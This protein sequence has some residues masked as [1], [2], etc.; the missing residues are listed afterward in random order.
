MLTDRQ[1]QVIDAIASLGYQ[2][3]VARLVA[4]ILLIALAGCDRSLPE[5]IADLKAG[6]VA[7]QQ[8]SEP[9]KKAIIAD[10]LA[11]GIIGVTENM[12]ML[13]EPVMGPEDIRS[14]PSEYRDAMMDVQSAP[15]EY[16]LPAPPTP[17]PVNVLTEIGNTMTFWGGILG[18]LSIVLWLAS[19]TP[20][21]AF[22]SAGVSFIRLGISIGT[23][24]AMVG[25]AMVWIAPY[26]W[27]AV[28]LTAAGMGY[29]HRKGIMKYL[30]H[31]RRGA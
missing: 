5:A 17:D 26:L 6:A 2:R 11:A 4:L 1:Q 9:A 16:K 30:K 23:A 15:P 10:G 7:Y 14:D 3:A 20:Y 31:L 25:A 8:E 12:P 29:Y 13:P 18:A 19:L 22:L 24:S 21:G 28:V 27:V